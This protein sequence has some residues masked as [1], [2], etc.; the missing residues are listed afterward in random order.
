LTERQEA[1][2][3]KQAWYHPATQAAI[4]EAFGAALTPLRRH[5]DV[6][7]ANV[8]L[9]SEGLQGIY[10]YDE[11]PPKG[12]PATS[13]STQAAAQECTWDRVPIDSW[14]K[15]QVPVVC[16]VMLSDTST[17]VGGETAVHLGNGNVIK[18][19]GAGLG[20]A[21]LMQS[22]NLEHAAMRATNCPE[23]VSMVTSFVFADP[24]LDDSKCTLKTAD[25]VNEDMASLR[26]EHLEYK[27]KKFRGRIDSA[28][29]RVAK[30]QQEGASPNREEIETWVK[31]QMLF[32]K[33]VSW[34]LFE[35]EPNYVGKEVP[36]SVF[37]EYLSD[38]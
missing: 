24:D 33:Q 17:M 36:D 20:G 29:G 22:G 32:L 25:Y 23:R 11:V 14:H 21:V 30:T 4:D 12:M 3:I 6:G 7:Y 26:L 8:Q 2:F 16:V 18:A 34:E 13:T 10:A 37:R 28:L 1:S 15:D 31:E 35:R 9:G 38:V 27:L 5:C 19:R